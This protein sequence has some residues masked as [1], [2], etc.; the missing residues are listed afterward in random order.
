MDREEVDMNKSNGCNIFG[1]PC[2]KIT[3]TILIA[4]FFTN[5]MVFLHDHI[6]SCDYKIYATMILSGLFVST[7]STIVRWEN[8]ND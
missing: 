2:W 5:I 1:Y 3:W 7:I 8:N 4:L 6:S